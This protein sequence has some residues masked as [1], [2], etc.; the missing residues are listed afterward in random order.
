MH[1]QT[2]LCTVVQKLSHRLFCDN[3]VKYWTDV[4]HSFTGTRKICNKSNHCRSN[5]IAKALL[6]Y[7]MKQ[8]QGSYVSMVLS[9]GPGVTHRLR[10]GPR[11]RYILSIERRLFSSHFQSVCYRSTDGTLTVNSAPS[12]GRK[13]HQRKRPAADRTTTTLKRRCWLCC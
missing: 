9:T 10:T 11:N 12:R 1:F 5:H 3:C 8:T 7:L 6:H 2:A 4:Q 13:P